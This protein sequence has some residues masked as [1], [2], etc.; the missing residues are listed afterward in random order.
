[1]G[2]EKNDFSSATNERILAELCAPVPVRLVGFLGKNANEIA[3][4]KK[5]YRKSKKTLAR[6]C[7]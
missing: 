2:T 7:S 5:S 4:L 1:V 6:F 3:V